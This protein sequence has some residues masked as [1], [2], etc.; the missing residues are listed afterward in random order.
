MQ[1]ASLVAL[2]GRRVGITIDRVFRARGKLMKKMRMAQ[3]TAWRPRC[4][5]L[6][7]GVRVRDHPLVREEVQGRAQSPRGLESL[8]SG[9]SEKQMSKRPTRHPCDRIAERYFQVV[10]FGAGSDCYTKRWS[11]RN[12]EGCTWAPR[13]RCQLG[14]YAG[15]MGEC[16]AEAL[17][18]K[19]RSSDRLGAL[20]FQVQHGFLGK[21]EHEDGIRRG[22]ALCGTEDFL[23]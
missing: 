22:Q 7:H 13:E 18:M 14:A 10:F 2:R 19:G 6:I 9:I 8:T 1:R 21:L 5:K 12:G 4:A 23:P 20:V 15:L 11:P 16:T 3:A 17:G